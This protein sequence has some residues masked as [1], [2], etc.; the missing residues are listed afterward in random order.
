M[1]PINDDTWDNAANED[2]SAYDSNDYQVDSPANA[3]YPGDSTKPNYPNTPL[4]QC[5]QRTKIR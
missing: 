3:V 4:R 5:G 1:I 2:D